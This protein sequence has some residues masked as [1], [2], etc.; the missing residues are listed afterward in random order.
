MNN[1]TVLV[2]LRKMRVAV[3]LVSL[4]AAPCAAFV[5]ASFLLAE[6][7]RVRAQAKIVDDVT[8]LIGNTPMV[9]LTKVTDG[10]PAEIVAKLESMEPCNSVKDRIGLS[11]VNEAE[12][13][14]DI[15]PGKTTLVEPTSGNT[16]IALAMVCAARGYKL[17]LTMPESMSMERRVLLK[18][19]P[20]FTAATG[21]AGGWE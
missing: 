4:L 20:P 17:I 11:M 21:A 14:G 9:R 7:A 2:P 3:A 19:R 13:R 15:V 16:G 18:V 1:C 12:V 6:R 10:C 8:Q 5:P